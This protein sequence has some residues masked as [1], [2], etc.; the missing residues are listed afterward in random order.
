MNPIANLSDQAF[1]T[2]IKEHVLVL[3][4]EEMDMLLFGPIAR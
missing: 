2:T 1:S 3:L 4:E